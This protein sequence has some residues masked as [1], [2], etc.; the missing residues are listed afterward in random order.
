MPGSLG[1]PFL[2]QVQE[3]LI[4]G[5]ENAAG[6]VD[7]RRVAEFFVGVPGREHRNGGLV[8]RRIAQAGVEVA[9]GESAG[10]RPANACPKLR[11]V[12]ELGGIPMIL[13]GHRPGEIECPAGYVRVD[14]DSTRKN[15]HPGSVK[16]ANALSLDLGDDTSVRDADI[17]DLTVYIVG[18]I[19]YPAAR[20]SQH[21]LRML[22]VDVPPVPVFMRRVSP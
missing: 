10:R 12:D 9:G 19:K 15:D 3:K 20:Y 7:Q 6:L 16:R 21:T 5:H 11:G 2:Q 13:W 18:R 22:L 1:F 8:D 17:P 4:V 14:I